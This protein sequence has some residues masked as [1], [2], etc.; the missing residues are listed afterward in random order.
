MDPVTEKTTRSQ[1]LVTRSA[2]RSRL[3]A[4]QSRRVA[5]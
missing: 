2:I 4:A 5:R 1:M 3:W